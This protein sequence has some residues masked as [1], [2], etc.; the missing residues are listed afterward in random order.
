[1]KSFKEQLIEKAEFGKYDISEHIRIIKLKMEDCAKDRQFTISLVEQK[2]E[3]IVALGADKGQPVYQ[4]FIP[5]NT[6]PVVYMKLFTEA[7]EDLG[8]KDE[9]IEKGAGEMKDYY[10]YNIKVK[11]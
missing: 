11:W 3:H 5:K 6:N 10:Y 7:L 8:F 4:T 2:P 1:M 9:D